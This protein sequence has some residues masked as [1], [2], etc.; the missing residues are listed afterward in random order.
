[1]P[2]GTEV[3]RFECG[4]DCGPPTLSP[5]GKFIT[6][7]S[8]HHIIYSIHGFIQVWDV[9]T[10]KK[11]TM[12][13]VLTACGCSMAFVPGSQSLA[14][15][16]LDNTISFWDVASGR[17]VRRL[18]FAEGA[19]CAFVFTPDG[20]TMIGGGPEH[21]PV[22]HMWDASTGKDLQHWDLTSLLK[23]GAPKKK[24]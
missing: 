12:N 11:R 19:P 6:A 10:G 5:D 13:P 23:P 21:N 7:Y 18:T 2:K 15:P 20:K 9:D 22:V 8:W 24:K 4:T 3:R 1:M 16:Q 17:E 14:T